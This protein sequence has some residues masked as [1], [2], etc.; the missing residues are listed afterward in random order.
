MRLRHS[1]LSQ[2][3][4][5][6]EKPL[7]DYPAKQLSTVLESVVKSLGL[8]D[9]MRLEEVQAAWKSVAGDFIARQTSPESCM[10]GVLTVRVSQPSVH[11]AL[12]ME[13]SRLLQKLNDH[14]GNGKVR[15][16][17]FRHG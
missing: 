3:R 2:W 6:P 10:K 9:R 13:K 1:L 17:K 8:G 5:L 14:L 15:E 11:H 7:I 4:G 12:M 16:I